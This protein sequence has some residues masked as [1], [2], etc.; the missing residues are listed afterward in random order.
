MPFQAG[1]FK[2]GKANHISHSNNDNPSAP[3]GRE[4]NPSLESIDN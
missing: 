3:I 1:E 4:I 2:T